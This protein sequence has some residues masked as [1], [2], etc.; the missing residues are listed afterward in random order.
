MIRRLSKARLEEELC[1]WIPTVN[2]ALDSNKFPWTAFEF[3]SGRK[4]IIHT[5][6][7]EILS[8]LRTEFH[9]SGWICYAIR[10]GIANAVVPECYL[11]IWPP[12]A[13]P[14]EA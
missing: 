4:V 6:N 14:K 13:K 1:G 9:K 8:A 5:V 7:S 3:Q 12:G 10:S 2:D 11:E